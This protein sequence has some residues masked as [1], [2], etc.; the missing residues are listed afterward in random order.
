MAVLERFEAKKQLRSKIFNLLTL[1]YKDRERIREA[2][3]LV[4]AA[5]SKGFTGMQ[6]KIGFCIDLLSKSLNTEH[7]A[8]LQKISKQL[9]R[10]GAEIEHA[11]HGYAAHFG[12]VQV[13]KEQLK[14]FYGFDMRLLD[15]LAALDAD[16]AKIMALLESSADSAIA[17]SLSNLRKKLDDIEAKLKKRND[18]VLQIVGG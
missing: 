7:L 3:K 4:R 5:I 1:G 9:D 18:I 16:A 2:D 15:D 14:D 13:K 10:L 17:Q 11:E 6:A 8:D 12:I